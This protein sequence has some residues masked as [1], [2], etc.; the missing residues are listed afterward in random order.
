MPYKIV[1]SDWV[2]NEIGNHQMAKPLGRILE[3][4]EICS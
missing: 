1:D 4:L 2:K 3:M